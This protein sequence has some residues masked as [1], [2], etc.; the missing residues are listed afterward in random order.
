MPNVPDK[1]D[2]ALFLNSLTLFYLK[3]QAKLL[4]P[5]SV[6]QTIIEDYQNIHDVSQSNLFHKL[7]EK[8]SQVGILECAINKIIDVL[9]S[10]DLLS[11]CNTVLKT[12][13]RR[14]SIFKE[15]FRYVEP[16]PV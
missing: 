14:K 16:K 7:T 2:E 1:A 3:L 10:E 5:S 11:Q 8:L 15:S 6:I 13:Q 12:D 4:L 9:K